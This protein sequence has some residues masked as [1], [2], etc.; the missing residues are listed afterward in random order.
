M[1]FITATSGT[2]VRLQIESR[3]HP[4]GSVEVPSE[5]F[6]T[7]ATSNYVRIA[8]L[9]YN[10]IIRVP[11]VDLFDEKHNRNTAS[12]EFMRKVFELRM[13]YNPIPSQLLD[14]V[15]DCSG[16]VLIDAMRMLRGICKRAIMEPGLEV[17]ES[18]I[19]D[20]FQ[21][22]VDDYQFVVDR[23]PLWEALGHMCRG[24]ASQSL[25]G[26]GILPELLY[27]MIAIEY[28][29][30]RA[31]FEAHPAARALYEQNAPHMAELKKNE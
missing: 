7:Y 24:G 11:A 25:S 2:A 27:K 8:G 5:P 1:T 13:P 3:L 22:L 18:V 17:D 6:L 23:V 30:K 15:L 12:Q 16:G 21:K 10:G 9:P 19:Q 31:W 4:L 26:D 20:G 29:D 14:K 28:S